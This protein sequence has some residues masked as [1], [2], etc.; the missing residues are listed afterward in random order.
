MPEFQIYFIACVVYKITF[1]L[2]TRGRDVCVHTMK[3]HMGS[4][5][6]NPLILNIIIRWRSL[7]SLMLWP[8]YSHSNSPYMNYVI[9]RWVPESIWIIKRREKFLPLQETKLNHPAQSAVTI[10]T[11]KIVNVLITFFFLAANLNK[12]KLHY[13][14]KNETSL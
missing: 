3:A 6:I 5:D 8:L 14:S 13:T 2:D 1:K 9:G 10:L 12:T 7:F 11:L 4:R